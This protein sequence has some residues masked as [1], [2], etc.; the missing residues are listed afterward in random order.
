MSLNYVTLTLDVYDGQGNPMT[1]G[2]ATFTPS[3]QLTDTTDHQI[4]GLTPVTA[5]FRPGTA[6]PVVKLLATDNS[7]PLPAGWAWTRFLRTG[8]RFVW[9][10]VRSITGSSAPCWRRPS[11]PS[12]AWT[13]APT[14]SS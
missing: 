2:T 11:C 1:K 6:P 3:A 9:R 12:R 8:C 4:T 13:G 10:P 5:T 14:P 7:A